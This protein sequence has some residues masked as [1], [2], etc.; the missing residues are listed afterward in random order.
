MNFENHKWNIA[1][2]EFSL[3][4]NG[5][6]RGKSI[7]LTDILKSTFL[8]FRQKQR[9]LLEVICQRSLDYLKER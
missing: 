5:T 4:L 9:S 8:V 7:E 2:D 1:V 6:D 3:W